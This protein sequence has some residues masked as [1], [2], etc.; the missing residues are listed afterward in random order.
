MAG[1]VITI[2]LPEA[3]FA[4]VLGALDMFLRGLADSNFEHPKS[5]YWALNVEP[6]RLGITVGVREGSR[7]LLVEES[8]PG[9]KDGQF[10]EDGRFIEAD[11]GFLVPM[12][13]FTPAAMLSVIAMGSRQIDHA[14]TALLAVEIMSIVGGVAFVELYDHQAAPVRTLH[15]V[16][17]AVS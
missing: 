6:E 11:W 16:L 5:G 1:P 3:L 8:G 7:P 13:G 4:Q 17:A 9:N 12:L 15:G 10:F 2:A 14:A